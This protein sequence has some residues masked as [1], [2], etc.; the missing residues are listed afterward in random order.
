MNPSGNPSEDG[1]LTR[2]INA[3][4]QTAPLTNFEVVVAD[5]LAIDLFLLG[6][7]LSIVT[8]YLFNDSMLPVAHG[9]LGSTMIAS[10][11]SEPRSRN[12]RDL[13]LGALLGIAP[14]FDYAI[15]Y[16]PGL[17]GGWHHGFTHSLIFG[18]LV[19]FLMSLCFG[20]GRLKATVIYSL[21]IISHPILDF[22][23][24]ESRGI[25]LLWPFTAKRFRLM[26]PSP[27]EYEWSNSSLSAAIFDILKISFLE[28][29]I[30]GPIFVFVLWIRHR[31]L[32]QEPTTG[33]Y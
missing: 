22:F 24:T 30:F 7:Y 8:T 27:I 20:K 19:G 4:V 3:K 10:L 25:E 12:S 18:C 13:L 28:L 11:A 31:R 21:A 29:M 33:S 9:L 26:I 6:F 14:D 16:V 23:F 15:H 17:G 2:S 5:D 32:V 1:Y